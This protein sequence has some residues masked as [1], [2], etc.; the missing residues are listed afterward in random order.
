MNAEVHVLLAQLDGHPGS[1]LF[2]RLAEAYLK[3][4]KMNEAIEV[5]EQGLSH[6]PGYI[7]GHLVMGKCYAR[8]GLR[9]QA[10]REF[11][12]TLECDPGH[13]AAFLN[14]GDIYYEEKWENQALHCYQRALEADPLNETIQRRITSLKSHRSWP[15]TDQEDA[16]RDDAGEHRDDTISTA[17]LAE[18]YAS[19]GLTAKAID[20][21]RRILAF[22]PQRPDII[23]RMVELEEQ[24]QKEEQGGMN[25]NNG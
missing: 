5:C 7:N 13:T 2:A 24:L 10:I 20:M 17:T 14:L 8:I 12:R 11:Q 19:Q 6:H 16:L 3:A 15:G 1:L 21:Y 18:I 22:L 4:D 9:D 25:G 23:K